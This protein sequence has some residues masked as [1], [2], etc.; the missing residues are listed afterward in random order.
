LDHD[1]ARSSLPALLAFVSG[2][3]P[4][5]VCVIV[6]KDRQVLDAWLERESH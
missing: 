1:F 3:L 2:N 4:G 6:G 5:L